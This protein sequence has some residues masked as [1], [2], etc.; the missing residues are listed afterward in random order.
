MR[1]Y[2]VVIVRLAGRSRSDEEGLTD[3]LNERARAGWHFHSTTPLSTTRVLAVF[4]RDA[5]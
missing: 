1:Q 2:E 3:L 4:Y 5:A